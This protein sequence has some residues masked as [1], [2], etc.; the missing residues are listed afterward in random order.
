MDTGTKVLDTLVDELNDI[1]FTEM[2]KS[3]DEIYHSKDFLET[4]RLSLI[5]QLIEA[6]Y[7]SRITKRIENR[8]KKAHLKGCPF[9][10][11]NCRDSKERAYLPTDITDV[12]ANLHF[13]KDGMNICILGPSDSGKTYLAKSIG[14][15]A[16]GDY[17]VEYH[18]CETF[19]ETLVALKLNDYPK[20]QKKVRSYT[21]GAELLIL[22]D[23][24]LHTL[25]E[26]QET[27]VLF[28]IMEKRSELQK[29]TIVCSQRD[30]K[31]WISMMMNDEVSANAI[32]K[33]A[34]KHYTVVIKAKEND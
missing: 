31:S 10:L 28:E 11:E 27:K 24:L 9:E 8:I 32:V 23:F 7:H 1:G 22:D 30:P 13:I 19:L 3:L 17:R 6:E 21:N 34:T 29:S 16:C 25:S 15:K 4:D 20:Y 14:I 12:L 2:A 26:E 5:S 33:R 18:H